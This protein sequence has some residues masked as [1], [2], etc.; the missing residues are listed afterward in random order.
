MSYPSD[1]GLEFSD[2]GNA[3][4]CL[5]IK[6]RYFQFSLSLISKGLSNLSKEDYGT[7]P[8]L[9]YYLEKLVSS[10]F[11]NWSSSENSPHFLS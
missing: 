9:P 11:L 4:A 5:A 1:Q 8:Q 10:N 6:L 3:Q 2:W 7:N